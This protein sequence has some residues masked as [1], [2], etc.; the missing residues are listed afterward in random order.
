[1]DRF[2]E[3]QVQVLDKD[4]R[5]YILIFHILKNSPTPDTL[6]LSQILAE[7]KDPSFLE[8]VE[9]PDTVR[10]NDSVGDTTGQF[11]PPS[12]FNNT[13]VQPEDFKSST[14]IDKKETS[15]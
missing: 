5:K 7:I 14:L 12:N 2:M 15:Q 10:V 13:P 4:Q 1:M 9:D 3:E 11:A 8:V 6:N